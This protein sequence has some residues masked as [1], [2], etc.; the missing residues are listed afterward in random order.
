MLASLSLRALGITVEDPPT[1]ADSA[2]AAGFSAAHVHIHRLAGASPPPALPDHLTWVLPVDAFLTRPGEA[3]RSLCGDAELAAAL[4]IRTV[5]TW[6][7]GDLGS[8]RELLPHLREA[9]RVVGRLGLM[10]AV[11]LERWW[12]AA[13][14]DAALDDLRALGP[15]AA[16]AIDVTHLADEQTLDALAAREL[17]VLDV[18]VAAGTSTARRLTGLGRDARCLA[19]LARLKARGYTGPV[20]AET[21]SERG[22]TPHAAARR[23]WRELSTLMADTEGGTP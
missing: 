5:S 9:A 20:L 8:G 13:S 18:H 7:P 23:A 19:L 21:F 17:P 14:L 15:N 10:M 1:V 11:E 16:A 4:G 22:L 6:L 12:A 2:A 3:L